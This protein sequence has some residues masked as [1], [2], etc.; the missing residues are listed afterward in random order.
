[1][2][3]SWTVKRSY[4]NQYTEHDIATQVDFTRQC[5]SVGVP[6]P[7]S[8]QRVDGGGYMLTV[9]DHAEGG[10]QYRVLEW[11]EGDVGR[12]DDPRTIPPI[13]EWMARIHTLAVDPAGYPIDEWYVRVTYDWDDLAERLAQR[14]PD[15]AELVRTH[16]ADLR[17]LA[18]LVN[19]TQEPGAVWCH[20]D[21]GASNLVWG[22]RGPQLI[23]WENAGPLV[24][25]QELGCRVR[26]LGPLGKSAYQTYRQAG[27]PAEITDISHLATSVAVHLNYVGAQAE[28][29]LDDEHPEQHEFARAQV[30]NAA[31]SVPSLHSLGPVDQGIEGVSDP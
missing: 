21:I 3:R 5:E 22:D 7:R 1:M 10:T 23:D 2:L 29:L 9:D 6:A 20:R 13:A 18:D 25:H 8:I 11:V 4:W 26:S 28:L 16:R 31:R 30:A 27:G 24:P 17:E 15:I 19:A 14:A 12:A